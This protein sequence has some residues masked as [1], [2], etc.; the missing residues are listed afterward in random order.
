MRHRLDPA[1]LQLRLRHPSRQDPVRP[2]DCPTGSRTGRSAGSASGTPSRPSRRRPEQ[3]R[4]AAC[5]GRRRP[6]VAPVTEAKSEGIFG[7]EIR[8]P[9]QY[10]QTPD[11]RRH[12]G[13]NDRIA[14]QAAFRHL[15]MAAGLVPIRGFA[16]QAERH[17]GRRVIEQ[18]VRGT[19]PAILDDDYR[20][21]SGRRMSGGRIARTEIPVCLARGVAGPGPPTVIDDDIP[22]G[23][24]VGQQSSPV[25]APDPRIDFQPQGG[26]PSVAPADRRKGIR[27]H[28]P[29]Q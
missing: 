22:A 23:P 1:K 21:N 25:A 16:A 12:I 26:R 13:A 19:A 29:G 20:W 5:Q 3:S 28:R 24:I 2:A 10:R 8:L 17:P 15:G 27:C 6:P 4:K 11:N 18:A 7:R 9:G 14:D